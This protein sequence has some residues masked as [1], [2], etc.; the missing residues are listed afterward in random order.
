MKSKIIYFTNTF[1]ANALVRS[2]GGGLLFCFNAIDSP[3]CVDVC[4]FSLHSGSRTGFHFH[5]WIQPE[6]Q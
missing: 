4:R 1:K 5:G 2:C 3:C 6:Q